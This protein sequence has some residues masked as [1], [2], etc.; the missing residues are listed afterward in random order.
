MALK[1]PCFSFSLVG[2]GGFMAMASAAV[3]HT[4]TQPM[5]AGQIQQ[6]RLWRWKPHD[7]PVK[8]RLAL[9]V[10]GHRD[11]VS[12]Y[13]RQDLPSPLTDAVV[14]RSRVIWSGRRNWNKRW[15]RDHTFYKMSPLNGFM[16]LRNAKKPQHL[17]LHHTFLRW[18]Y[19]VFCALVNVSNTT[20][21]SWNSSSCVNAL[22][23]LF[24]LAT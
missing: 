17:F 23:E 8:R 12:R 14:E 13:N 1:K 5:C 10:G 19:F 9:G 6:H 24:V 22:E 3:L 15:R 4:Q 21:S 2:S 20:D 18:N 16:F 7:S 11:G